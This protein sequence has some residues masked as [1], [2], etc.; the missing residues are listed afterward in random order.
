MR[1]IVYFLTID[2]NSRYKSFSRKFFERLE[3]QKTQNLSLE[4]RFSKA[5]SIEDRVSNR[6]YQLTFDRYCRQH[7][8]QTYKNDNYAR[9]KYKLLLGRKKHCKKD[10]SGFKTQYTDRNDPDQSLTWTDPGLE[11]ST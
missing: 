1:S 7:T 6:D 11:K 4:T 8:D 3:T 10:L 9:Y 2:T 5:L